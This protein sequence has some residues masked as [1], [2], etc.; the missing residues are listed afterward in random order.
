MPRPRLLVLACSL[1]LLAACSGSSEGSSPT[2]SGAG[3]RRDAT[4]PTTATAPARSAGC[5]KAPEVT[6]PAQDRPGDVPLTFD[7]DGTERGYRLAIPRTYRK[8]RPAPL[9]LNL[10]GS[11]S[12]AVQ[13]SVY[14]DLPRR[15][16]ALGYVVVTP[17]AVDGRWQLTPTGTDDDFLTALVD[18]VEAT[19]CIDLDRVHVTGMSLGA[20][21]SALEVCQHPDR[22]ASAVLVTVEVHPRGC[23]PT[24]VL[25][26]H[27]TADRT[28]PYGEGSDPGVTVTGANAGLPGARDNIAQWADAAGC[29]PEPDTTRIGD[30]VER[31][32]LTGCRDGVD[33]A[34]YTIEG[35]G[36]TWPG[37]DITIGPTTQTVD[38]T[39]LALA[40]FAEHPHR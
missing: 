31:R 38:A 10:H 2:T 5:G 40:W 19:T 32:A 14:S 26:F 15:G 18:H 28:V 21:K 34:L 9:I 36:H 12:N 7:A 25:A 22:F 24:S 20:W 16:G 8:D 23:G 30:D 29:E 27:G 17:D 35:G 6:A 39:D 13:Q 37:A 11:G 4:V 1:L 33:V 3:D